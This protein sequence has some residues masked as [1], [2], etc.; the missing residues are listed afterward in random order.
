MFISGGLLYDFN[1]TSRF[2]KVG[3]D[4]KQPKLTELELG[5]KGFAGS[6]FGF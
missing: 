1:L 2:V 5:P 4:R 3:L 6:M